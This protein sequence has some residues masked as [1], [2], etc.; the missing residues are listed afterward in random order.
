M[1]IGVGAALLIGSAVSG[2][3]AVAGAKMQ[4]NA[5]SKAQKAQQAGT[6]RAL[7]IQEQTSAPYRQLGQQGVNQL[8]SMGAPQPYTQQ[9]RPGGGAPSSNGVQAFNPGQPM[10]TLGSIGQP[11]QGSPQAVPR[12]TGMPPQGQMAMVQAPTGEV[13]RMAVGPDLD[14]ALAAGAKRLS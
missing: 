7:Q 11:P 9:F 3:A 13:A 6:D 4:S 8:M 14:K 2:G 12:S 5:A 10:P 1:P